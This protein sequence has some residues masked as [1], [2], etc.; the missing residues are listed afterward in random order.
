MAEDVGFNS[1][2][3][4]NQISN[5]DSYEKLDFHRVEDALCQASYHPIARQCVSE[6]LLPNNSVTKY[7]TFKLPKRGL[8][9]CISLF[10]IQFSSRS[11]NRSL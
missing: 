11:Q 10:S 8:V 4:H 3:I 1:K 5:H 9:G 7:F 6:F 2:F